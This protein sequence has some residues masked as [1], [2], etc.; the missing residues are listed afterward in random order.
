MA[1]CELVG[2]EAG[3]REWR[4]ALRGL[5]TEAKG[6][7]RG[8][9][10][11]KDGPAVDPI[12]RPRAEGEAGG[13][14]RGTVGAVVREEAVERVVPARTLPRD[15]VR[16]AGPAGVVDSEPLQR[17]EKVEI[18]PRPRCLRRAHDLVVSNGRKRDSCRLGPRRQERMVVHE[19][20]GIVTTTSDLGASLLFCLFGSMR[21]ECCWVLKEDSALGEDVP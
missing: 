14:E 21:E 2:Q 5:V 19:R 11:G 18:R 6:R 9:E 8:L 7:R 12:G 10:G 16:I 20:A 15:W 1:V 13:V 4:A 3:R 17:C